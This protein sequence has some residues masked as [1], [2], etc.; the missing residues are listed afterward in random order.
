MLPP[1][2]SYQTSGHDAAAEDAPAHIPT[3]CS[4][5]PNPAMRQNSLLSYKQTY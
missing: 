4:G 5:K 2:G 3:S 1:G